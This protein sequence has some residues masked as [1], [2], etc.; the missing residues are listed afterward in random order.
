M[1]VLSARDRSQQ[2]GIDHGEPLLPGHVCDGSVRERQQ[3]IEIDQL[4]RQRRCGD[5]ENGTTS[6]R[7]QRQLDPVM[8]A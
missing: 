8:T 7:S 6:S 3:L 2:R 1:T 5:A 4:I